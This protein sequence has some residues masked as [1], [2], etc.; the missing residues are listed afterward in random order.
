MA[1]VLGS[2]II[3]L[4]AQRRLSDSANKLAATSER[5]ASGQRIN[6]ASDDAAGLAV[7]SG[8]NAKNRVYT[9]AVRNINDGQSALNVAQGALGELS[10][11]VIRQKE[12]AEQ[13]ANGSYSRGQRLQLQ[14]EANALVKEYNRIVQSTQF[15][16]RN[17]LDGN[18][19][20]L[21]VQLGYGVDG[22]TNV[23]LGKKGGVAANNMTFTNAGVISTSISDVND[24]NGDGILDIVEDSTVRLGRG[25]GTFVLSATLQGVYNADGDFNG[26][27]KRD[28]IVDN[29]G[30]KLMQLG[31]GDGT[32]AA[33][34]ALGS[35]TGSGVTADFNGDGRDELFVQGAGSINSILSFNA[36]GVLQSSVVTGSNKG[37]VGDV[38]SDGYLDL[39]GT[40]SIQYGKADGT[41]GS[42]QSFFT[43]S[44]LI[45]DVNG[46]SISDVLSQNFSLGKGDGTFT[47]TTNAFELNTLYLGDLNGDGHLD[48][49]G[50]DLNDQ[51]VTYY[52]G[53]GDGT[54]QTAANISPSPTTLMANVRSAMPGDF[55]NDGMLDLIYEDYDTGDRYLMLANADPSGRRNNF[56]STFDLLTPASAREALDRTT[57]YL[58]RLNSEAASLGA[59]QS[60]LTTAAE[61]V[62]ALAL[63]YAGAESRIRD[64][65]IA[66]EAADLTRL[67]IL[68]QSATSILAQANIQPSIGIS[69]IQNA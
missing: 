33:G 11:I 23:E 25:D 46:D 54:F 31:R 65:D 4:R 21:R 2:N 57:T 51:E 61:S 44:I 53:R 19:A 1:V 22:S 69:L 10:N 64:A 63:G 66:A 18:D 55:N 39:F 28:L 6:R 9:Q 37:F 5:L 27:G 24:Y 47:T 36:S 17:L 7:A 26:D 52:L 50:T 49:F 29:G 34:F 14:K 16:G 42:N 40:N 15:N 30:S 56:Q 62:G 60:R 38:N 3:S 12:L 59:Y 48:V 68:K 67:E 58:N 8:L 32:F 45:A 20:N 35:S 13:A 43:N 41:F